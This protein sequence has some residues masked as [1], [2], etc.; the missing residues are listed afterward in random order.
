MANR[1]YVTQLGRPSI[2]EAFNGLRTITRYF[3]VNGDGL[4]AERVKDEVLLSYGTEDGEFKGA[5]LV[6][7]GMAP[8]SSLPNSYIQRLTEVYQE[9]Q[10]GQKV[11]IGEDQIIKI[12]DGRTMMV[13]RY[14]ALAAEAET[15]AAAI[16]EIVD[17]RACQDVKIL[18]QGVGAEVVETYI[19]AGILAQS[20]DYSN[21]G[22]LEIQSITYFNGTPSTPAGFTL[23]GS[24]IQN[25]NGLPGR[26]YRFARG[27]GEISRRTS[28]AQNGT[29]TDGSEG[30]TK[31]TITELTGPSASEP[32][33]SGVSGYTK[34]LVDKDER[35]GHKVWRAVYAKGAGLVEE[36]I[37]YDAIPGLRV[38]T[39]FSLGTKVTPTGI[40]TRDDWRNDEGYRV[41][42]VTAIQTAGGG[43]DPTSITVAAER[44][45]NFT[46]PG[47]AK[48]FTETYDGKLMLAAFLS[49]PVTTLVKATVTI[50]YVTTSTLG[51]PSPA[52]WNPTDWATIK[53]QWV[54]SYGRQTSE[55]RALPGYRSVSATP[56]THTGDGTDSSIEGSIIYNATTARITVTG[57]PADPGGNSYTLDAEIDPNPVFTSTGGTKYYRKTVVTADIPAQPSLPV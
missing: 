20:T 57:G 29:T 28:R 55:I 53:K 54:G 26:T 8:V 34:V 18:K 50:S 40:V 52:L 10:P 21:N 42:T 13:R 7:R 30:V 48:A 9:F 43:A 45:V 27:N 37:D 15:I 4:P 14:V 32:S 24:T 38:V 41:F 5:L 51:S 39:D 2:E 22:L 17:G 56:V 25:P 44:Y 11:G 33:W 35:D 46:Y 12:E 1:Q 23:I 31:L 3:T 49:P 19:S 47:R 16:G 36:R 6:K